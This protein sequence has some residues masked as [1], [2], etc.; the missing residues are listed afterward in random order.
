[1]E[2]GNKDAVVNEGVTSADTSGAS[3][4]SRLVWA[5]LPGVLVE[6][7]VVIVIYG[8]GQ[9]LLIAALWMGDALGAGLPNPLSIQLLT[10]GSRR[11]TPVSALKDFLA[12]WLIVSLAAILIAATA[13]LLR[14]YFPRDRSS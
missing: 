10:L 6:M 13:A 2:Q 5:F 9:L 8:F 14:S 12:L 7:A 4:E 3:A 1:M 11:I